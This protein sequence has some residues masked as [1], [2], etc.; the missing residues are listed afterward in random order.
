VVPFFKECSKKGVLPI[1]DPRM[2]R[3]WISLEQGVEFVLRSLKRMVGGEIFVP[4][5]PSMNIMDLAKAIAPKCKTKILG[6]RPGEKLHE[7]MVPKDEA[8]NAVEYKDYYLI[9]PAFKFFERVFCDDGCK[10][11]ADDFEYSSANN[12]W[13]LTIE[14]MKTMV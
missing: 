9:K 14:E 11:V 5:L 12:S 7:V 1:T 4:K 6:I 2:T 13:W 8:V 10:K 3:F